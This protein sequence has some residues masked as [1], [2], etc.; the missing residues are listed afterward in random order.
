MYAGRSTASPELPVGAKSLGRGL[1]HAAGGIVVHCGGVTVDAT[2]ML[3]VRVGKVGENIG[4]SFSVGEPCLL[5]VQATVRMATGTQVGEY[6]DVHPD[7]F[8][9]QAAVEL[10]IPVCRVASAAG[11]GG[12]G[13]A[14]PVLG[15]GRNGDS[16]PALSVHRDGVRR[17]A[18]PQLTFTNLCDFPF[19]A[20][21][22][23]PQLTSEGET[24]IMAKQLRLTLEHIPVA[25]QAIMISEVQFVD[26]LFGFSGMTWAGDWSDSTRTSSR[27]RTVGSTDSF[28]TVPSDFLRI[29]EL[30]IVRGGLYFQLP[31]GGDLSID[32][33]ET[34]LETATKARP[35][36]RY[37]IEFDVD[38]LRR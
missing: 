13:H 6:P 7:G 12:V 17:P 3:R 18:G 31:S 11:A 38:R 1:L 2:R 21:L 25:G 34:T 10:T 23:Q 24:V 20:V 37:R 16:N 4:G 22:Q 26:P 27:S 30:S 8:G 5:L 32:D 29:I 19:T 14:H 9:R 33:I 36:D 35:Y 28:S 15:V